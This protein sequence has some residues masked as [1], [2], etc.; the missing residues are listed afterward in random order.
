MAIPNTLI[1][2]D[3]RSAPYYHEYMAKVTKYQR[4]LVREVVSDDEAPAPKPAKGTTT[5]TTR[6][7]KLQSSKTAPEKKRK[8]VVDTTEA[9]P[10]AKRAKAGKV[11]KKRT[12]PSTRQLVDEFVDEGVPDKEQMYGDEE[13]DTQRAIEE[14][15]KKFWCAMGGK[16]T[17]G[18]E[19]AAHGLLNLQTKKKNL[20]KQFIFQRRNLISNCTSAS[21]KE[22]SSLPGGS[23]PGNKSKP[24]WIQ[25]CVVQI[26][27]LPL[28]ETWEPAAAENLLSAKL[29]KEL[30]F[31][32]QFLTAMEA[33]NATRYF[34]RDRPTKISLADQRA[35]DYEY[36]QSKE[37]DRKIEERL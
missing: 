19:Q 3:M 26:I 33:T 4:Y 35:D 28:N 25:T 7:P 22:S 37:I 17:V 29:D 6:K 16:E 18:E 12:L 1:S 20:L 14:S 13:A 31:T 9:L 27:N 23:D 30:S 2:E 11:L 24:S 8:L 36:M 15:L 34:V 21:M 10:Q 5:K 32:D